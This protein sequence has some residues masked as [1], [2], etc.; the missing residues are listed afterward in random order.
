[1]EIINLTRP[2]QE[3]QSGDLVQYVYPD[4]TIIEKHIMPKLE[5]PIEE[6]ADQERQWR[7][8]ELALTDHIATIPDYP[9][10]EA[11][12]Q[13]RTQLRDYPTQEDFPNGTRPVK[14]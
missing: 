10:R 13:Y 12:L 1:M 11:Y 4:G 7:N 2:D 3:P 6:I 14:P 8:A 9:N 5:I